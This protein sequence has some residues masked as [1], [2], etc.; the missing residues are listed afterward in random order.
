MVDVAALNV[1]TAEAESGRHM[2][3]DAN[4]AKVDVATV[5]N[6]TSRVAEMYIDQGC[7]QVSPSAPALGSE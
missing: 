5:K 3:A 6:V 4:G 1:A 2:W 7:V